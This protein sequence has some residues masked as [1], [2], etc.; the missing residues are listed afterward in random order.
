MAQMA[1]NGTASLGSDAKMD[2]VS[3]GLKTRPY[4]IFIV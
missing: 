3:Y 1:L 2:A 4:E